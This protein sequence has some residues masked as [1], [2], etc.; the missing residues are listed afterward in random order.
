MILTEN[1]RIANRTIFVEDENIY[2]QSMEGIE[3]DGSDEV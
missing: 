2:D 1:V 3:E